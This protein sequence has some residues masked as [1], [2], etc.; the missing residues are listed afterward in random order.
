MEIVLHTC[1]YK[2]NLVNHA[3]SILIV[4]A[5]YTFAICHISLKHSLLFNTFN[6]FIEFLL[7]GIKLWNF[8]FGKGVFQLSGKKSCLFTTSIWQDAKKCM[9]TTALG[10]PK[11]WVIVLFWH[12]RSKIFHKGCCHHHLKEFC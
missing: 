9:L 1:S 8:I 5:L 10:L 4:F 11:T 6:S 12:W 2:N 3:F 7:S